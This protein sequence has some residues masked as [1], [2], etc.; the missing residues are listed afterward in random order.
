MGQRTATANA[1][2]AETPA[3]SAAPAALPALIVF[4]LDDCLWTPE[5]HELSG[6]PSAPVEGP[7]DP[8]DRDAPLGTVGMRV[9]SRRRG[10]GGGFDWGAHNGEA[11]EV[12]EL[13]PGA[14][15]VLRELATEP[16]YAGVR[17][18]VASTSLEPAY[19]RACLDGIEVVE[20][21]TLRDMI[22]YAQIGR[23]GNLTSRKT[24]HFRLLREESGVPY[25]EMLF[26]DD[27]NWGD[28]VGDLHAEFGVVGVRTPHGLRVEDFRRGLAKFA[29]R[30][31]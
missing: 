29:A 24:T 30:A 14:R 6:P 18:A 22:S 15:R 16:R 10:R 4:D 17:I 5:M 23:T 28:H 19:S 3:A 8:T 25:D 27:C 7:L 9:P 12:V 13:Y 31:K 11:A 1:A 2:A 26:F 20:D 21:T